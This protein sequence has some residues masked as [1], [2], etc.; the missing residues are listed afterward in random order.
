LLVSSPDRFERIVLYLPAPLDGVRPV[1][2]RDRLSRLLAAV[3]SGEAASVADVVSNDLPVAV[4][5]SPA[6]WSYLRQ[7]VEQLLRDGLAD[8]LSTLWDAPA[9]AEPELL[10]AFRG[11]ALV[12][13]CAGDE[14]HP[15]AVA[16]RLAGII[17]TAE[18]YVYDRPGVLWSR[19]ADLRDRI[20]A[21]LNAP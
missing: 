16:E 14:A 10:A 18:L 19:R 11:R 12:I 3:E 15:S 2:V 7:R 13:G 6:G 5:N 8:E 20:S 9:V 17:P 21:F 4:R 1:A